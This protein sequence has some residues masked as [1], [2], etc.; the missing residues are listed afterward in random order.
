MRRMLMINAGIKEVK[1]NLSRYLAYVKAGE[2]VLITERGRPVARI[3]KENGSIKSIRTALA[4][5]VKEGLVTL[6]LVRL[7]NEALSVPK[8]ALPGKPLSE[9]VIEDRR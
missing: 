5:L 3:V 2:D 7:E 8:A 1:N 6:P 9:I 4:P